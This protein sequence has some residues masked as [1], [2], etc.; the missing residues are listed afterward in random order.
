MGFQSIKASQ[1]SAYKDRQCSF[2]F[3]SWNKNLFPSFCW[4]P[5]G[6]QVIF[7]FPSHRSKLLK[8]KIFTLFCLLSPGSDTGHCHYADFPLVEEE[9]K[10]T[11]RRKETIGDCGGS[12]LGCTAF[13]PTGNKAGLTRHSKVPY[14]VL[15][16]GRG[17]RT[18]TSPLGKHINWTV[19]AAAPAYMESVNICDKAGA[20][21]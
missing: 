18:M 21:V 14:G 13:V 4:S 2:L 15:G 1:R 12:E 6:F 5:W 16:R 9:A 20:P 7:C 17:R 8:N 10:D 11:A 19:L 3:A